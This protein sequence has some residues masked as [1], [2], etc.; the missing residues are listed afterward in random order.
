MARLHGFTKKQVLEVYKKMLLS[1]K[2]DEKML[3][4]LKQGKSYFHIG[5]SGHEAAEMAAAVLIHS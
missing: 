2:L 3:I 1:R 4:L 5:A